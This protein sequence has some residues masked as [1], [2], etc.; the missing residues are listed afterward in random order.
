[1]SNVVDR[2]TTIHLIHSTHAANHSVSARDHVQENKKQVT[3]AE[4]G[5]TENTNA[6]DPRTSP[7]SLV[8]IML[9][10]HNSSS[11]LSAVVGLYERLP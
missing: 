8:C 10:Q 7:K 3:S 5:H 4:I 2:L 1:M 6:L 11:N 9:Q